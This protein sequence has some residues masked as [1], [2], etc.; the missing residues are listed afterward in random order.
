MENMEVIWK[1]SKKMSWEK[2]TGTWINKI[3]FKELMS[4]KCISVS[5]M[6]KNELCLKNS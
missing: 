5:G 2:L 3:L 1:S 4:F 6:M